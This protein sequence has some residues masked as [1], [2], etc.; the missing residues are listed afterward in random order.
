MKQRTRIKEIRVTVLALLLSLLAL[1]SSA[2]VSYQYDS[3][4]GLLQV[5][6]TGTIE[7]SAIRPYAMASS[8]SISAGITTIESRAFAGFS[9]LV[10]VTIP[11]SVTYI[12]DFAFT[13]CPKL[14]K[15]TFASSTTTLN[16][17]RM[18]FNDIA[19][20][21][22]TLTF[23]CNRPFTYS[24]TSTSENIN[25]TD[26]VGR[27]G[28]FDNSKK[29]KTVT[30]GNNVTKIPAQ[31]F[32]ECTALSSVKMSYY[33]ETIGRLAFS[34]C[35]SL[36][37]INLGSKD[38]T[39]EE[40]AFLGCTSLSKVTFSTSMKAIGA[41]AFASC[42]GLETVSLPASMTTIG[43]KAFASSGLTA[44]DV[45][46]AVTSI[47][48]HAFDGCRSLADVTFNNSN[49]RTIVL[50]VG[51]NA[52]NEAGV[53][54]FTCYRR[55][56]FKSDN[57]DQYGS[58]LGLFDY[59]TS[60]K[61]VKIGGTVNDIPSY[62]FQ[63]C[64]NLTDVNLMG[65]TSLETI[66]P[67]AFHYCNA[68]TSVTIP[69]YA[70]AGY[71]SDQKI[72]A[73]A[74]STCTNLKY[75]SLMARPT[76]ETD[77]F[78]ATT[79]VHA[80]LGIEY[81]DWYYTY[82][83]QSNVTTLLIPN[84]DVANHTYTETE[85]LTTWFPSLKTVIFSPLVTEISDHIFYV[86]EGKTSSLQ[87]VELEDGAKI[88]HFS[89]FEGCDALTEVR[90]KVK[91]VAGASFKGCTNLKS[92]EI[93]DDDW[94]EA[95]AFSG[96]RSLESVILPSN[97]TRI[98]DNA[99]DGCTKLTSIVLPEGVTSVEKSAFSSI[100]N[101]KSLTV[102]GNAF[103]N[104]E[105][106]NQLNNIWDR[107]PN[108]VN[109]TFGPKVNVIHDYAYY[110]RTN[111]SLEHLTFNTPV[112]VGAY[113]F[114]ESNYKLA[115]ITGNV[116]SVA[117][118]SFQ[119]CMALQ[120]ITITY[121][122]TIEDY[123]FDN[124]LALKTISLPSNLQSIGA[125]AFRYCSALTNLTLPSSLTTIGT[126]SF[127]NCSGFKNIALPSRVSTIGNQAFQGC[128]GLESI[129]LPT[130]L[131][132][133]G[134]NAFMM[135]VKL[136]NVVIP[137][138]VTSL[139]A[140]AFLATQSLAN[141]T[142][143]SPAI[144][145]PATAYG[146]SKNL[147]HT[148]PAVAN[149]TI[150]EK[151]TALG[152]NAF[153]GSTTLAK[154]TLSAPFK[155]MDVTSF[156]GCTNLTDVTI[157][158]NA[159]ASYSWTT[160][161]NIHNRLPY[162]TD[163][164]F[165]P[166]VTTVSGYAF[167]VVKDETTP[168]QHLSFLGNPTI[169]TSSF[170]RSKELSSITGSVKSVSLYSFSECEKLP[171][172]TITDDVNIE[173]D[174]FSGCK[175]LVSVDLPSSV[176]EFGMYAFNGCTSL[177]EINIPAG[178]TTIRRCAFYNCPSLKTVICNVETPIAVEGNIFSSSTFS[179]AELQV[180]AASLAAYKAA[181]V[182]KNFFHYFATDGVK[183]VDGEAY[184]NAED[185]DVAMVRY[186]RTFSDKVAGKWQCLYVPFDITITDE[187]LDDFEFAKLYM[188][189]YKDVDGNGEIEDGE[190][191]VM[192]LNKQYAGKKL[193]ANTP[194]FIKA[195]TSGTKNIDVESTVLKAADNGTVYCCTTEHEYTLRGI[196]NTT[197]I[198]GYYTM[199]TSGQF[200]FYSRDTNLKPNRWYMEV[201]SLTEDE[202][203]LAREILIVVDG[204]DDTDGI[205]NI[206]GTNTSMNIEGVYTL[207][208]RK[209]NDTENLPGGIYIV[210][211]KKTVIK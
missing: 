50:T 34:G 175:S 124:C 28:I 179:Q 59:S 32:Q 33:I 6:G 184:T 165:G 122:T 100:N 71:D 1:P 189:S 119:N 149:L 54:N 97:L 10:A 146:P 85:N 38:V 155:T 148:F 58:S 104:N 51:N 70:H 77:A 7:Y 94:I 40:G 35:T 5:T 95:N 90:G 106:W 173:Q 113:A 167:Y 129:T 178:V 26:N 2:A 145:N 211:G 203:M 133:I 140:N 30:I 206:H 137:E 48:D 158:G 153:N 47:G 205:I 19:S 118:G 120:G 83:R 202:P 78:P 88:V 24:T 134:D 169:G 115:D 170:V 52:F 143:N 89:A 56:A 41:R 183:L 60:L 65:A 110:A 114:A 166:N 190:P 191:L 177:Q 37:S 11:S 209:L 36:T 162:I 176:T 141:L 200:D 195:L 80:N 9:N 31:S 17:G 198:N 180:P 63:H 151:V 135:C 96:C 194:Y 157:N 105:E 64:S 130:S 3:S 156:E 207:D 75:A 172:I 139:G 62:S 22:T 185:K 21:V 147:R 164:T 98:L 74:F 197:N 68:L 18:V 16:L 112:A 12:G 163:L 201:N 152:A 25:T 150:G 127:M 111:S 73:Y 91:S 161:N 76:V 108:L 103:A 142:I 199:N 87:T 45:P 126:G 55:Y 57:V 20:D 131:T 125:Y 101:L 79:T 116:K 121:D 144:A 61:S 84:N 15:V 13:L 72:K 154:L 187:L 82:T 23:E 49:G 196:Y 27:N 204:E 92:I 193:R 181:D 29:L 44:I 192:L 182:W 107:F 69:R 132:T 171:S 210:N 128:T 86:G 46:V 160:S 208:G 186:T 53:V 188:I 8:V 168:L 138:N 109:L 14:A 81:S 174:A 117:E 67:Y 93:T 42:T 159:F 136:N 102:L 66:S 99:F 39:L 4:N 43:E 123:A